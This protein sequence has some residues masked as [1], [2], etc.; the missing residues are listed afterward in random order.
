MYYIPIFFSLASAFF[1]L[2]YNNSYNKE[3]NKLPLAF[4]MFS[5][6]SLFMLT[7]FKGDVEPDYY[8]YRDIFYNAPELSFL[9]YATFEKAVEASFGIEPGILLVSSFLKFLGLDYQNLIL[10]FS[11]LN[12]TLSIL[13]CRHIGSAYI[14]SKITYLSFFILIFYQSYFVQIRFATG[15]FFAYLAFFSFLKGTKKLSLLLFFLGVLFHNIAVLFLMLPFFLA[16]KRFWE[17]H[18][19][20]LLLALFVSFIDFYSLFEFIAE[21]FF[22]RYTYY[23]SLANDLEASKTVFYWRFL[24]YSLLFFMLSINETG[25]TKS[26]GLVESFLKFCLFMNLFS[27]AIGYN[28]SIFYRVAWFFDVGL[29]YF[30]FAANRSSLLVKRLSIFLIVSVLLIYR[31][32]ASIADFTDYQFDW[33][34]K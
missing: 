12:I 28:F 25:L 34:A 17:R 33:Y 15:A 3:Y 18:N 9:N 31:S 19:V 22:T 6:F 4:I 29:L 30:I 8:N 2:S 13:I 11:V 24:V 20:V 16:I 1:S 23:F 5:V 21:N 27:W 32:A 10:F 14:L 7:A 26:T